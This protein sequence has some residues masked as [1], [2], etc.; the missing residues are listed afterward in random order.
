MRTKQDQGMPI[1]PESAVGTLTDGARWVNRP[2]DNTLDPAN[3]VNA[4]LKPG[5]RL[6]G[7]TQTRFELLEPLGTG[8]MG[9]VFLAQD[10]VL[11]RKVAI[12]FLRRKDLNTKEAF[13][14][15]QH[16]AQACARLNHENIVRMFDIGQDEGHPFLVME[17]LEGHPL[18]V[19]MRRARETNE[20]VVDVRRAVRLMIDVA[21]GLSHAHRAGIVHRDL[22]PSNVF[23][24]RDGTAKVLDFGVAQ[25]TADSDVAGEYFLGTPQYM[26]PEQWHGHVQDGQTDI[27]AAGVIFF[28]LLTGVSPFTGHHIAEL[29]NAVLSSD[30][31]PSLR[32]LRPELPEEA[33]EI[34]KRALEKEKSARFGSADDLLDELVAL[35]VLLE[36][37]LR[38]QSNTGASNTGASSPDLEASPA[39]FRQRRAHRLPANAERRQITAMACSFSSTRSAEALDDSVGEF[40]EACATIVHQLEGTIL[41]SLGRQV[42]AC[43]GYP[44]AHEDSA[45]RALRAASLI[46]D[47]FRPDDHRRSGGACVGVATGPC[48]PLAVDPE[49]APLRMQ[50]EVLDIAQSLERRAR[51][52]EILTERPTQM[53]VQGTFELALLDDVAPED[54]TAPQHLYRLLRR[55]ENRIRFN[56]I[57]AG[58]VTPLVGRGSE[59]DE[60][61]R[62]WKLAGGGKGQFALVVGEAGIGKSRLLEQHLEALATE[63]HRFV[64]C[65]CWPHSQGSPLQPILEGLE[66][67]VG[68]DPNASPLEKAAL[69]G[70]PTQDAA[71]PPMSRNASLLKHQMLEALVGWFQRLAEQEPLLLVLEDAHWADSITLELLERWLSRLGG[72]RAMVLVTARPEF[73]PLWTRSSILHHLAP[74]R[75]SPSESAALIGFAGRGRHLPAAIVE[76]VVQRADGVPLFIEELTYS[77][78]D[79]LQKGGNEHSSWVGAVPATLEALLRARLDTLPEPGRELA[80]VASVL[81]R[82]MNYDLLRAMCPL[83]EESLRIGLLQ[84]VETGIF[85]PIGPISRATCRFKHALVQEAAYQ[86]LVKQERQELH[87]RAAEVLVSQFSQIAEQNPEIAARHFAE[88]MRP[89]EACVYLEKAAKQ[90]MQRSANIDALNHYARAMAQLDLLP[91][92]SGRDRRELLLKAQLAGVYLAEHG[93]ESNR[94]RE[95]LSRIRELAERY[96]GD[97]Q[98][99]WALLSIQQLDH[100]RGEHRTGRELAA[101]LMVRAEKAAHQGMILAAYKAKVSSALFCGDLTVCRNDAEAGIRLYEAEAGGAIRVHMG[102]DVGAMLHLYLGWTFWLLGEPDQ[103]I[104]HCH[105][106]VRI[107]RKYDHPASLTIRLLLLA[108]QHN[109]RGEFAEARALIDEILSLCEEYG[110]HFVGAAARV[111]RACTQIESGEREGVAELQAALA[112]RASMGATVGFTR[113]ISVL[114]HGQL[115]IGALDEAMLSV[116]KAMEI[117]ERTGEHYCD[118]ELLRLKG[119]IL[120]A[121]GTSND[122]RAARVFEQGLE[123]ARDQHARSWELRLA[124]SYGRLLARQGR[125]A[126]AKTLLAPVLASFTE[127]H[128]T[129]DLRMARALAE[130]CP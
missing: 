123:R 17:H 16:E 60:L 25:M 93:L 29:R 122:G 48:I 61:R 114:A 75:L 97:E 113:Y 37:A 53:L 109:D 85:R 73:Q 117:S 43:F 89:E 47:A 106:G 40:F 27:W 8:G 14:R 18:D 96:D 54:G 51:P 72:M 95:T 102:A 100:V 98:S 3:A 19:I 63:G 90:A 80:R 110:F 62:L 35:E 32:G 9:V 15:V 59:L 33:E 105:E 57:A 11:D 69:L 88:A 84:L 77:V 79:A 91:S 129:R 115:Q 24:T 78:V 28:E 92:S 70:L 71:A 34:A 26:S 83:S 126:E 94:V 108:S 101:Q 87:Q 86:S 7:M 2:R 119:E 67:S 21:K 55:K 4:G 130:S 76:Q 128:G 65:Q 103:A 30:P 31:S 74:P 118:A 1:A 39:S 64:R 38:G 45:Q 13:G 46:V 58:N 82:E 36:H 56:P 127:G 42:V 5:K 107:A 104:R 44:R 99:F 116:D 22:K 12:K 23:I 6:G 41:S 52:N 111:V 10:T 68:L 81:G 120:V 112:H 66:H 20:A 125:M 50:G 124:C 121:M 49:T